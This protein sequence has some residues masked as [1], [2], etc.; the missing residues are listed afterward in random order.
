VDHIKHLFSSSNIAHDEEFINL[1]YCFIC[2]NENVILYF[3][4]TKLE[5]FEALFSLGSYRSSWSAWFYCP[6]LQKLL[7]TLSTMMSC[8]VSRIYLGPITFSKSKTTLLLRLFQNNLAPS[9]STISSPLACATLS[10]KSSLFQAHA[11]ERF[12]LS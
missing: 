1:F 2:A 7:G 10:T 5:I 6:L 12:T 8:V 9:Q 3:I 4:L 11:H